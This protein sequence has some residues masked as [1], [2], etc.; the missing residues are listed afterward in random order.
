MINDFTPIIDKISSAQKIVLLVHESPDGDAVGSIISLFRALTKLGKDVYGF[1]EKVPVNC[2]FLLNS[3]GKEIKTFD[4]IDFN[5]KYDLCIALDCGDLERMGDAKALF[6]NAKDT[7]CIDHHFTN[8]SFA[9]ANYIDPSAAATGEII[10]DLL[11]VMNVEINKDIATALYAAIVSDTG[12]FIHN[13]T[14]KRTFEIA[15]EL[16]EYGIDITEI[17]FH[18]FSETSLNRMI[19]MGKLLQNVEI[20]LDGKIAILTANQSDIDKF[21]LEPSELDGMVDYARYIKG[22]EVGIFLKPRD[23]I[24][25]VSLRSNGRVDV[26][27]IA[28]QFD[29]GGHKFAAGCKVCTNNPEVAKRKLIEAFSSVELAP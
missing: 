26:S 23:D 24:Y 9:N 19:F 12:N 28:V 15:G 3:I 1:I 17:S 18:M 2:A 22:V 5:E 8:E 21:E 7:A 14:T 16:I 13:N 20:F 29:G 10:F 11:K 25:K 4:K 27:G 6:I